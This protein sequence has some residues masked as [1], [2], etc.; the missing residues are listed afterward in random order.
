MVSSIERGYGQRA[1]S[2]KESCVKEDR[3][4]LEESERQVERRRG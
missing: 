4:I 2:E 1:E 3:E